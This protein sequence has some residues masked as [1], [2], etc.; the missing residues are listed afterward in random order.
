VEHVEGHG[1]RTDEN[2]ILRLC[3]TF[4]EVGKDGTSLPTFGDFPAM[5]WSDEKHLV[6]SDAHLFR[7][8]R[9]W[10]VAIST[11]E[12][13]EAMFCVVVPRRKRRRI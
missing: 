10:T 12:V 3:T 5:V 11:I 13:H 1:I 4:H 9:P 7:S 2:D 6:E 8:R